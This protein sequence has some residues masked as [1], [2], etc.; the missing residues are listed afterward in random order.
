MAS[1][2]TTL[3]CTMMTNNK[4]IHN[5]VFCGTFAGMSSKAIIP[6]WNYALLL[7]TITSVFY[8]G[9]IQYK[10]Q[11]VGLGGRLGLMAFVST[12]MVVAFI[13]WTTAA[14]A[15]AGVGGGAT[16]AAVA[17]GGG[18][19]AILYSFPTLIKKINTSTILFMV[20]WHMVGSILTIALRRTSD[21]TR[22]VDPVRAASV[23][24]MAGSLFLF[25]LLPRD[26][27]DKTAVLALYGG[28]FVGMSAPSRLLHGVVGM[29]GGG[30]GGGSGDDG[31]VQI[32]LAFGIA[33]ALAGVVHGLTMDWGLWMGGWGG[34]AGACAFVGCVLY[35]CLVVCLT[36]LVHVG[37][38]RRVIMNK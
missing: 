7:G 22:A 8:E 24:G 1:S 14:A 18:G 23:V 6:S 35:R 2:A 15:A 11:F 36:S 16:A 5:A 25:L 21:E 32:G 13:K 37:R 33:A 26:D 29:S 12:W 17:T 38:R 10:N 3:L 4:S 31:V 27:V 28:S 20:F 30:A 9:M 19:G 34:K